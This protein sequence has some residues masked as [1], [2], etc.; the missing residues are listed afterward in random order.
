MMCSFIEYS[1]HPSYIGIHGAD[2]SLGVMG[3]ASSKTSVAPARGVCS[4]GGD[5]GKAQIISVYC[6]FERYIYI[7]TSLFFGESKLVIIFEG[8]SEELD[9]FWKGT[10][11]FPRSTSISCS[12]P[13]KYENSDCGAVTVV[14]VIPPH[15]TSRLVRPR[16]DSP[17]R[18]SVF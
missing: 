18:L 17:G 14:G 2:S 16:K 8:Y 4:L 9:R 10:Q 6:M 12:F 3:K 15:I 7:F 11:G 13:C 1:M 5:A